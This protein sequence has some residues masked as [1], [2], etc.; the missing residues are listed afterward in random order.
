MERENAEHCRRLLG[1]MAH[2]AAAAALRVALDRARAGAKTKRAAATLTRW[3]KH[4]VVTFSWC[5][6]TA[7][8]RKLRAVRRRARSSGAAPTVTLSQ[9]WLQPLL[10]RD[11]PPRTT[12][13]FS[14]LQ[15]RWR[16]LLWLYSARRRV[17]ARLVRSF[18]S[19]FARLQLPYLIYRYRWSVVKLQVC[20]ACAASSS[21]G[22][23]GD[24]AWSSSF[25]GGGGGTWR[26]GRA[27]VG[28][29]LC[30]GRHVSPARSAPSSGWRALF[31]GRPRRVVGGRR[32]SQP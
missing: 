31:L 21:F 23:G 18:F 20:G 17:A 30:R 26:W 6:L 28:R 19:D 11:H 13:L 32:H 7:L 1:L 25:G 12:L 16:V 9:W 15:V 22:G 4:A 5:A 10:T 27:R 2:G 29:R 14:S 3:A 24:G 8:R